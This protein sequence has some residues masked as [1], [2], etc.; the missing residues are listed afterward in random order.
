MRTPYA[1]IWSAAS[2]LVR[3]N[4]A[5]ISQLWRHHLVHSLQISQSHVSSCALQPVERLFL[6][7][8]ISMPQEAMRWKLAGR[9]ESAR[10]TSTSVAFSRKVSSHW[11]SEA[12][13]GVLNHPSAPWILCSGTCPAFRASSEGVCSILKDRLLPPFLAWVPSGSFAPTTLVCRVH[14][15]CLL[16]HRPHRSSSLEGTSTIAFEQPFSGICFR[17]FPCPHSCDALRQL[18]CPPRS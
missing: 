4:E 5:K 14:G 13:T 18:P 6:G 1:V 2:R 12:F 11:K 8:V 3:G 17:D 9:L 7:V 15:H 10:S 16:R